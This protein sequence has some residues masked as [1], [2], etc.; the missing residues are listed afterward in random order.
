MNY[1]DNLLCNVFR[2]MA[3]EDLAALARWYTLCYVS[4]L[5]ADFDYLF[6]VWQYC[7]CIVKVWHCSQ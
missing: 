7:T 1:Y 3:N 2:N 4:D 5:C 6:S